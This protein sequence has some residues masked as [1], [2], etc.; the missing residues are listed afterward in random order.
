MVIIPTER[1][2]LK[3]MPCARTDHGDAPA[4]E[5]INRPS[6]KP[7]NANPKHKKRKVKIFGLRFNGLFELHETFGIFLIFK[8]I[9]LSILS[10]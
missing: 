7:N 5:T 10:I 6:P 4:K 9:I 8:N 1:L 2:I 3:E